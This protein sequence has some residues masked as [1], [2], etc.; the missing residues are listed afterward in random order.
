[1]LGPMTPI[2]EA[3]RARAVEEEAVRQQE[4]QRRMEAEKATSREVGA[5]PSPELKGGHQ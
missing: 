2:T 4:E 3:L 1:M 5:G